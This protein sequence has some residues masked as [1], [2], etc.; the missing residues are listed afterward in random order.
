MRT[1]GSTPG[2]AMQ[3]IFRSLLLALF[4]FGSGSSSL[5]AQRTSVVPLGSAGT[6]ITTSSDM[7]VSVDLAVNGRQNRLKPSRDMTHLLLQAEE[8]FSVGDPTFPLDGTTG[9][10]L[11]VRLPSQPGK[12]LG[13]CGAG[14]EDHLVLAQIKRRRLLMIDKLLLQSCLQS[15]SLVSDHGDDPHHALLPLPYPGLVR[16][17]SISGDDPRISTHEVHVDGG[18]LALRQVGADAPK[19]LR[20][21]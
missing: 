7:S 1:S 18:R 9:M 8:I 2:F 4:F 5:A 10:A 21:D 13:F 16:F 12:P 6:L 17:E 3:T 14:H 19:E 15:I 11:V 20:H